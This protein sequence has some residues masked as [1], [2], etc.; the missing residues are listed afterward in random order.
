MLRCN[1]VTWLYSSG[2]VEAATIGNRMALRMHLM[3]CSF[4]RRYVHE[5]TVIGDAV[6]R[7]TRSDPDSPERIH[8][9]V[10]RMLRDASPRSD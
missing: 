1:E 9:L 7:M 2:E 4:C 3:M 8:A 10:R 5:L 6:R